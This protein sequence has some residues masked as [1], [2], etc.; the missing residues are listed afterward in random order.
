[1]TPLMLAGARRYVKCVE[2]LLEAGADHEIKLSDKYYN[3]DALTAY[4]RAGNKTIKVR[5]LAPHAVCKTSS[6]SS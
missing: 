2:L 5:I 4:D 6:H 1:M 3:N